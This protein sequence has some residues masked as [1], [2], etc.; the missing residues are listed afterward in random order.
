[1]I[2]GVLVGG[3]EGW[4]SANFQRGCYDDIAAL[5]PRGYVLVGIRVSLWNYLLVRAFHSCSITNMDP[6]AIITNLR[7]AEKVWGV[8]SPQYLACREVAQGVLDARSLTDHN[9]K[10][11]IRSQIEDADIVQRLEQLALHHSEKT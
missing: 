11:E 10:K 4:G 8:S 3:R 6:I 1:M 2:I 7:N 9:N 5:F